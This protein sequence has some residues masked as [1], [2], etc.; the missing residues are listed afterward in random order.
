M[1]DIDTFLTSLYVMSEDYCNHH[2]N[3]EI[4]PG[5]KASL[6]RGEVITLAVFGQWGRFQSERDFYRYAH[7]NLRSAFPDLPVRLLNWDIFGL[8]PCGERSQF[9]RSSGV[10]VM[11]SSTSVSIWLSLW[12][13]KSVLMKPSIV[14]VWLPEM[15]SV[16]VEATWRVLLT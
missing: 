12:R 15:P 1:I 9:N 6:S 14:R 4:R 11:P 16:E 10:I 13:H 8:R 5:P 7:H 2:V 3:T